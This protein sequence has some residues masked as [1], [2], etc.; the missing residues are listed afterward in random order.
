MKT[1]YKIFYKVVKIILQ[2]NVLNYCREL[3][4]VGYDFYPPYKNLQ[5]P[6]EKWKNKDFQNLA[7]LVGISSSS[8]KRL[9]DRPGYEGQ[10]KFT[11]QNL[12][13]IAEFLGHQDWESC[14]K[15]FSQEIKELAQDS[16]IS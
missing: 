10:I 3:I 13:V 7:S 8:I 9:F 4:E 16:R 2:R 15:F 14:L 5:Q 11:K 6:L 1:E 12:D